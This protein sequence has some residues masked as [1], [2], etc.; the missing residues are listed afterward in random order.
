MQPP[1][2]MPTPPPTIETWGPVV[3]RFLYHLEAVI[4]QSGDKQRGDV[5]MAFQN[6]ARKLPAPLSKNIAYWIEEDNYRTKGSPGLVARVHARVNE[7]LHKPKYTGPIPGVLEDKEALL[8][9]V[10]VIGLIVFVNGDLAEAIDAI[11]SLNF[12]GNFPNL[13][14]RSNVDVVYTFLSIGSIF[15]PRFS[16]ET[17][18]MSPFRPFALM[19]ARPDNYY[20]KLWEVFSY[21]WGNLKSV[22]RQ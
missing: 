9:F 10:T 2:K 16:G 8:T 1:K 19:I 14:G 4:N 5:S 3:W 12:L 15:E 22:N 21:V 6:I 11:G 18:H 20:P 17:F 13:S 7:A